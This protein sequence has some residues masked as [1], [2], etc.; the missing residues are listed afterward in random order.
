M[1]MKSV[2]FPLLR[3]PT[4]DRPP[5]ALHR[6]GGFSMI[7]VL[8]AVLVLS[9]GLLGMAALQ[10]VALS[11]TGSAD[12]RSQAITLATE[13]IDMIRA[14]RIEAL[15]YQTQFSPASCDWEK[16]APPVGIGG[17][18]MAIPE[19]EAWIARV[20]CV[21]PQ[22]EGLVEVDNTSGGADVTVTLTWVDARWAEDE[23]EDAG[24]DGSP[25][26][27]SANQTSF[28]MTSRI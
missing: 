26:G 23:E 28:T 16:A 1:S 14:N 12:Q 7:E 18:S 17:A 2:S 27:L 10:A 13:L 6:A 24:D 21:L 20:Q 22:A 25:P 4:W 8:I 19:R 11:R 15:R 9:V 3:S 5:Q